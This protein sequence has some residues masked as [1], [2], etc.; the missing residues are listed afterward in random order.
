MKQDEQGTNIELIQKTKRIVT[1][2][3]IEMNTQDY[4]LQKNKENNYNESPMKI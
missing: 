4:R 2:L 3:G 1:S